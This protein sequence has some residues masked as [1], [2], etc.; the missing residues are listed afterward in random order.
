MESNNSLKGI[1]KLKFKGIIDR[2]DQFNNDIR[3]IDYKT[4]SVQ[5]SQLFF[6]EWESIFNDAKTDKSFQL[7]FYAWLYNK[8][9]SSNETIYP[10]I[11]SLK[12]LSEGFIKIK[13][14]DGT[15]LNKAHYTKFE[16]LLINL[17]TDIFDQNSYFEQT[18]DDKLC[19]YCNYKT[20]CNR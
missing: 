16:E 14:P 4:G 12:K 6:K 2:I 8:K 17:I 10:G 20:L 5:S 15:N 18:K 1:E 9:T 7:A 11:Y 3:I 13:T 19:S